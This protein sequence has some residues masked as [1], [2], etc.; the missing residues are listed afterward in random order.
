MKKQSVIICAIL[1]LCSYFV[2]AQ[3]SLEFTDLYG[4]Y[5][6]QTP[7]G[8]T[9][10]VFARGF[11][12]T[13]LLEHSYPSFTPDGDEVFWFVNQPPGQNNKDWLS[14]GM[15][16][17]RKNNRWSAP[18]KSSYYVFSPNGQL[19]FSGTAG[20]TFDINVAEKPDNHWSEPRCLDFRSRFPEIKAVTVTSVT[21]NKS[22]CEGVYYGNSRSPVICISKFVDGEYLKPEPFPDN[23]NHPSFG[24]ATPFISP[25]ESFL[26]FSSNRSDQFGKG[27]LYISFQDTL[28]G[29]WT[30]PI[31]MGEPVNSSAQ[32]RLPGVSPDGKYLFF[33]RWTPDHDQDIFWVSA[34]II[35]RL[36]KKVNK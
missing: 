13:D 5:L 15:T 36:R 18:F 25:D 3:D 29:T 20:A 23:I 34:K 24:R 14:F 16:M 35:N 22:L 17:Q 7:P 21:L 33:T 6:D 28:A 27:D 19:R 8:D 4:D 32:E 30:D 31:N 10:V 12:S 1:L 9:P 26:I 2:H 11:I